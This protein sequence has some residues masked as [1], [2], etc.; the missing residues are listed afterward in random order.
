MPRSHIL[1]QKIRNENLK[2]AKNVMKCLFYGTVCGLDPIFEGKEI[3]RGKIKNTL[4]MAVVGLGIILS[5]QTIFNG[6][7]ITIF[8]QK[9]LLF[10]W[11]IASYNTSKTLTT[12]QVAPVE[13]LL[14]L[15]WSKNLSCRMCH[16]LILQ[17]RLYPFGTIIHNVL[18]SPLPS[19]FARDLTLP[20]SHVTLLAFLYISIVICPVTR[21]WAVQPLDWRR[22]Y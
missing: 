6:T 4:L 7:F 17:V 11:L 13:G 16:Q 8:Y 2:Q 15:S 3:T 5:H 22:W 14:L 9:K 21:R 1:Q 12:S 18:F 10:S 20:L 19:G